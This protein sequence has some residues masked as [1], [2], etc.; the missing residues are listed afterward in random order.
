ME[1][2]Y[3]IL[4]ATGNNKTGKH[5]FFIVSA[6]WIGLDVAIQAAI[7]T[8]TEH[9]LYIIEN[10]YLYMDGNM[11]EQTGLYYLDLIKYNSESQPKLLHGSRIP[12]ITILRRKLH[13]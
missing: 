5:E 11:F 1:K 12:D 4:Q 7:E 13:A 6:G 10:I 3:T 8:K 9:K 2:T